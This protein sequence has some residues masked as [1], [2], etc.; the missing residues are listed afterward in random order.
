MHSIV[1]ARENIVTMYFSTDKGCRLAATQ[2]RF[3]VDYSSKELK[4]FRIN[5]H[6]TLDHIPT[7]GWSNTR[8]SVVPKEEEKGKKKSPCTC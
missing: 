4:Q 8:K 3:E 1:L 5:W 7:E 6:P 2:F